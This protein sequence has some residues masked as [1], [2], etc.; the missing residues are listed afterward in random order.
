MLASRR[1]LLLLL[2]AVD[3]GRV[4]PPPLLFRSR[5]LSWL[6][7]KP[8]HPTDRLPSAQAFSSVKKLARV[9]LCCPLPRPPMDHPAETRVALTPAL[10]E[11]LRHLVD[12]GLPAPARAAAPLAQ[13]QAALDGRSSAHTPGDGKDAGVGYDLVRK[14]GWWAQGDEGRAALREAELGPSLAS[15]LAALPRQPAR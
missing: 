3:A 7:P 4:V 13:L 9:V 2:V 10:H 14:V 6:S 11:L 8:Q 1:G 15:L 5:P 12:G